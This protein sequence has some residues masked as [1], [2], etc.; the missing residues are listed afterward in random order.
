MD[1]WTDG[2]MDEL[3]NREG[4][5]RETKEATMQSGS[6]AETHEQTDEMLML[7]PYLLTLSLSVHGG[8]EGEQ[9]THSKSRVST[10]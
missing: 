10:N 3:N 4:E 8:F 1:G 2:W 5:K 9:R 7:L 6:L